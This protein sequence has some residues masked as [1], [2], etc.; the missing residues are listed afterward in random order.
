MMLTGKKPK[1]KNKKKFVDYEWRFAVVILTIMSV[2]AL[3]IGRSAYWAIVDQ[4]MLNKEGDQRITS[5]IVTKAPRGLITDRNG[6]PLAVSTPVVTIVADTKAILKARNNWQKRGQ[7]DKVR[8]HQQKVAQLATAL[9]KTPQEMEN[10]FAQ[11]PNNQYWVLKQDIP[12]HEADVLLALDAE[13][14]YGSTS[15]K[16]FYPAREV[17]AQ[18]LGFTRIDGT[19]QEGL[20]LYYESALKGQDGVDYVDKDLMGNVIR[21]REHRKKFE[22]GQTLPL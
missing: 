8:E 22:P 20:E 5:E 12:P 6:E 19:G 4:E 3:V 1:N 21:F 15:Y 18:V 2:A 14:I 9:G 17:L 16:R 10:Y 11:N 7:M 13:G